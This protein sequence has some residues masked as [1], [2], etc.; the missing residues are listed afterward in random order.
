MNITQAQQKA[1]DDALVTPADRLE[2]GK[3]NKRLKTVIK[4]K[5][6]TFEVIENKDAKKTNKMPYPRFTKVIINH[7]MLKDQSISRRNKMFWHTAQDD[8]MFTSMRCISRH[9]DTQVYGT[10]LQKHLT[11]EAML[12]S[13]AYQTY[14]AFASRE[15]AP[16]PKYIQKKADSDTSPKNKHVQATK[17]EQLKLATKR[18]K[19]NFHMSYASGSGDGVDIQ[20]KS[21]L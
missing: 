6:A 16:K 2:F 19:N 15:K 14:Y 13:K 8:T 11:N 1:L 9:E 4:P 3:C 20:S 7:F 18:S 17:A 12:E 21:F 5:E 10:L